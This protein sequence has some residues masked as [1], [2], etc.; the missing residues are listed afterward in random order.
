MVRLTDLIKQGSVPEKTDPPKK[1]GLSFKDI[2]A[3]EIPQEIPQE[4]SP[5]IPKEEQSS[6]D[7]KPSLEEKIEEGCHLYEE[8]VD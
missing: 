7:L 1:E 6:Q 2:L 4:I 3:P 5:E 8:M